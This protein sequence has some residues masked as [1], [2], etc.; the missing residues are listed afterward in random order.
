MASKW[1]VLRG[2]ESGPGGP[3]R[4]GVPEAGLHIVVKALYSLLYESASEGQN[5]ARWSSRGVGETPQEVLRGPESGPGGVDRALAASG[6]PGGGP[7]KL[8]GPPPWPEDVHFPMGFCR[9]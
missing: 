4:R 3:D 6:D 7:K 5:E 2:P 9:N 1:K 8:V